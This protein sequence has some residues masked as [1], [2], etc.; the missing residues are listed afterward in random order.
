ML[1]YINLVL[2]DKIS[3][4]ALCLLNVYF[5]QIYEYYVKFGFIGDDF[6]KKNRADLHGFFIEVKMLHGHITF[7]NKINKNTNIDYKLT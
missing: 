1:H 3:Y 6:Y 4:G 5:Q 2:F 7:V